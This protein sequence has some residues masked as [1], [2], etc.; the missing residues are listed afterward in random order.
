[1]HP[2]NNLIEEKIRSS[3]IFSRYAQRILESEPNLWDELMDNIQQP[4][5]RERMQ[6]YLDAF[7]NAAGDKNS[8]YSALRN[9]RKLVMLHI[10]ARDLSGLA[11]LSEVME[12]MTNLAEV[13]ICFS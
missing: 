1:M 3:L 8:L 5:Q 9:L 11:D 10:A 2:T 7:P 6:T 13:T 12:C 4:F